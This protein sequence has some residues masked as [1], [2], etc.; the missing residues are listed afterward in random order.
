M[1]STVEFAVVTPPEVAQ[2]EPVAAPQ[3]PPE[4]APDA[5]VLPAAEPEPALVEEEQVLAQ[6]QE[7]LD[8]ADEAVDLTGV[9]LTGSGDSGWASAVGDGRGMAGPLG[10]VRRP[11]ARRKGAGATRRPSGASRGRRRP[12]RGPVPVANLSKPPRAPNLDGVLERHYPKQARLAGIGGQAVVRA[13]IGAD[14]RVCQVSVLSESHPGFGA[15][16][17]STLGGS[18]WSSPLDRNGRL[19]ST[20]I[21]Y[22][23]SFR[24]GR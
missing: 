13:R 12:R 5:P 18:R 21:T 16:C 4:M 14:G 11:G 9:T 17:Q 15:A 20:E 6:E 24:V 2:P 3:A 23:C 7:A 19:V 1:P 8:A 22:T 10:P